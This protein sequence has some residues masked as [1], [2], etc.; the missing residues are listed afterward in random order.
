ML[1]DTHC[2]LDFPEFAQDRD[3]VI[4]RAKEKGVGFIIN[5][6]SSLKGSQESIELSKK[7]DFIYATVGL[8]PHEADNFD[9]QAETTL[10]NLVR[11]E[12]VVAIGETGLDYFKNYSKAE[13]QKKLFIS[14]VKLAKDL[15]LPLIIHSR[16]AQDDTLKILK[17]AMPIKAVVH[18]FSG[19]DDFLKKC[20][21]LG[22]FISFTC[23][24]TY[25]KAENLRNLVKETPIDRLFLETDAPFLPPQELRGKRNEPAFVEILAGEFARIKEISVEEVAKI[26]TE[27]A[28]NFFKI[29]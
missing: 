27:N 22:F 6:G 26:T 15:N 14:L 2:H 16:Q 8:H 7:Y 24:I 21:D 11:N 18:C 12:K 17:E 1:I 19:G 13:N 4:S 9:S 5:I 23:N 25:P 29:T 10:E 20:L 28:K 3:E